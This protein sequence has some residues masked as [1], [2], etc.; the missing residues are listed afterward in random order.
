M[1]LIAGMWSLGHVEGNLPVIFSWYP[2]AG[3][4][5]LWN[6]NE[7]NYTIKFGDKIVQSVV[8]DGLDVALISRSE[9]FINQRIEN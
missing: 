1:G 8:V 7:E 4:A 2:T 3:K 6:V 9:L 5:I